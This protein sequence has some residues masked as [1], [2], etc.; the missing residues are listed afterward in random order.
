MRYKRSPNL[1][2]TT[3]TCVSQQ[4]KKEK[5]KKKKKRK[6]KENLPNSELCCPGR[7]QSKIKRK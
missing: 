6:E 5:K 7:P 4:R 1:G 3:R 2:Q